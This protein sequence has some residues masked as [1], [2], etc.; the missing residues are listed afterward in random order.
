MYK[1]ELIVY[2]DEDADLA[3]LKGKNIVVLGYGNQGRSQALN[4]R[5]SGLSVLVASIRDSSA[6]KAEADG[7]TVIPVAGCAKEWTEDEK[8]GFPRFNALI[9]EIG[10]HPIN[11]AESEIGKRVEFAH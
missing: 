10:K 5:D 4:M 1:K 9:E 11:A 3:Q 6:E 2:R 8:A 7:F